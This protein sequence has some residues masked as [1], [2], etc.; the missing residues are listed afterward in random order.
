MEDATAVRAEARTA[1]DKCFRNVL[2]KKIL[3]EKEEKFQAWRVRY[4]SLYVID[5]PWGLSLSRVAF[6]VVCM[7]MGRL[8]SSE[9]PPPLTI[10]R[11]LYFEVNFG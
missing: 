2:G 1:A 11:A 10:L 5:E 4:A 3:V 9:R 6:R 8:L 7:S